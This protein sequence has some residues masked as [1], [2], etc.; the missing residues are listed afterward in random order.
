MKPYCLLAFRWLSAWIHLLYH[1]SNQ[2]PDMQEYHEFFSIAHTE[3][4]IDTDVPECIR[5][6]YTYFVNEKNIEAVTL[7]RFQD[8]S[9]PYG[10]TLP[11]GKLVQ[12]FSE[13]DLDIFR[14][15][16][17]DVYFSVVDP[18]VAKDAGFELNT[19]SIQCFNT[20]TT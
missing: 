14:T 4:R 8:M 3:S 12:N 5:H 9:L 11:L 7:R 10:N 15:F 19:E 17:I 16:T 1:L 6:F 20:H 13:R 2:D 18:V